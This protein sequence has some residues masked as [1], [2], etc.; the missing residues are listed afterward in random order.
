M[1]YICPLC[2]GLVD[3]VEYCK[4]CGSKMNNAGRVQDSYD[5]YSP[6]L[7]YT[8]TDIM[9]DEPEGICQHFFKCSNCGNNSVSNIN[10]VLF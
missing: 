2:N 7:S 8:L 1:E 10:K 5:D 4:K 3:Y 9:D 6:Y